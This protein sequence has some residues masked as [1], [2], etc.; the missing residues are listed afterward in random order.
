L[1]SGISRFVVLNNPDRDQTGKKAGIVTENQ[2][3]V[4]G[5]RFQVKSKHR[6]SDAFGLEPGA[7]NLGTWILELF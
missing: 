1:T 7:W 2:F 5:S 6:I 3:Q 4:P